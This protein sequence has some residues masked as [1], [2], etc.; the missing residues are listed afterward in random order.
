MR[1]DGGAAFDVSSELL[2]RAWDATLLHS[3]D[4]DVFLA[5]RGAEPLSSV[6]TT[7][8][9]SA[10]GLWAMATAPAFQRQGAGRALL[11]QV[12][13]YYGERA[14][15]FYL[16]ATSASRHLYESLGFAVV[17]E[18]ADWDVL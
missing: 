7:R 8:T 1:R 5:R 4:L 6:F 18:A 13:S 11:S 16:F 15:Y 2:E 9:G 10:I 17:D 12:L 3:L 14:D